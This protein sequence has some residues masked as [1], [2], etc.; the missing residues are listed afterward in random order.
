MYT[1]VQICEVFWL[2]EMQLG[3]IL[4][5]NSVLVS[6]LVSGS[7]PVSAL[8]LLGLNLTSTTLPFSPSLS[9]F[10]LS[11]SVHP[12]LSLSFI[13]ISA[14]SDVLLAPGDTEKD[15][16]NCIAIYLCT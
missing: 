8:V 10:M 3:S 5:W 9:L 4:Q 12:P 15:T 11:L 7:F 1:L 6:L 16:W 2:T 14:A 13:S